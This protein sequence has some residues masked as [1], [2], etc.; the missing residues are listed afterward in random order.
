VSLLYKYITR[1]ICLVDQTFSI[2]YSGFAISWNDR[3]KSIHQRLTRERRRL[4]GA[5]RYSDWLTDESALVTRRATDG[6]RY[7]DRRPPTSLPLF[8]LRGEI[9]P[10]RRLLCDRSEVLPSVDIYTVEKESLL[11]A[12]ECEINQFVRRYIISQIGAS[13]PGNLSPPQD[14]AKSQ[15]IRRYQLTALPD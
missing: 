3:L 4:V 5:D 2:S 10:T 12:A 14:Y 11:A 1:L 13:K 9:E 15:R 7:S 6:A 8:T